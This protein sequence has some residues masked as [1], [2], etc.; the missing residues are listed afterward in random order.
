[1]TKINLTPY[2]AYSFSRGQPWENPWAWQWQPGLTEHDPNPPITLETRVLSPTG[3]ATGEAFGIHSVLAVV[4][5]TGIATGE[6]FGV[7]SILAQVS[8]NG[9]VSGAAFGVHSVVYT[10]P[11]SPSPVVLFWGGTKWKRPVDK[12]DDP[13]L[14]DAVLLLLLED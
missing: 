11:I 10:V 13:R 7:H 6:A 12:I 5:P 9:I 8:P 2:G 14:Q 1:M 3:I 4:A